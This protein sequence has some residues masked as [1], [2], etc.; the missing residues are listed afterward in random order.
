M[1][2]FYKKNFWWRLSRLCSKLPTKNQGFFSSRKLKWGQ[3]CNFLWQKTARWG[4][5][6]IYTAWL[7]TFQKCKI[8]RPM[9]AK[10]EEQ[11]HIMGLGSSSCTRYP[12]KTVE[13][14]VTIGFETF[15]TGLFHTSN[16]HV[17]T[18]S[19]KQIFYFGEIPNVVIKVSCKKGKQLKK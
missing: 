15:E 19:F 16:D 5:T 8:W 1:I 9:R 17:F 3:V 12:I 11:F 18:S 13:M 14:S 7:K 10:N 4:K 2:I 6:P